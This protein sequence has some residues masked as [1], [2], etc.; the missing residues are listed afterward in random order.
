M[1]RGWKIRHPVLW[2]VCVVCAYPLVLL[3]TVITG[4]ISGLC[5]GISAGAMAIRET[6]KHVQYSARAMDTIR[7]IRT[8]RM[9]RK[10]IF[11]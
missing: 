6:M 4:I 3:I 1:K 10:Q 7:R 5:A 8:V 9:R 2:G 11:G